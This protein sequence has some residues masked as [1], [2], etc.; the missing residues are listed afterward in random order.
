MTLVVGLHLVT[1]LMKLIL[2]GVFFVSLSFQQP[3]A[4]VTPSCPTPTLLIQKQDLSR[5]Q[6]QQ[7]AEQLQK[8]SAVVWRTSTLELIATCPERLCNWLLEAC[9]NLK[10]TLIQFKC[11]SAR[12]RLCS[13]P[14]FWLGATACC[15]TLLLSYSASLALSSRGDTQ[16][17]MGSCYFLKTVKHHFFKRKQLSWDSS[18]L[19]LVTT[20]V[21]P[22][23][24]K[25]TQRT[26]FSTMGRLSTVQQKVSSW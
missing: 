15:F 19:P 10:C 14:G 23:F 21:P 8:H 3:E 1:V 24:V 11:T 26:Y 6:Q 12:P 16:T 20:T 13:L 18:S 22:A 2:I 5:S 7:G 4:K 17:Y 25:A 9:S